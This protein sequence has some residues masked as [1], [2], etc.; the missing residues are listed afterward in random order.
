MGYMY[1]AGESKRRM[2]S[3]FYNV[4]VAA[5]QEV[6]K[7]IRH[8]AEHRAQVRKHK[9][10]KRRLLLMSALHHHRAGKAGKTENRLDTEVDETL[11][12][13][14]TAPAAIEP[15]TLENDLAPEETTP[16]RIGQ[17][18]SAVSI[19]VDDNNVAPH[20]EE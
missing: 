3:L 4:K 19:D 9:K 5:H 15:A 6:K 13:L 8:A 16:D 14:N 20:T 7:A 2:H 12:Q 1:V 11:I 18:G 17:E 10:D